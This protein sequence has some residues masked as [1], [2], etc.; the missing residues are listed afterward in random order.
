MKI[1]DLEIFLDL[2][3]TKSPTLTAQ[4]FKITQPNVSVLI[5]NIEKM[6]GI[7]LFERL[8]KRLVP[9]TRALYLGSL[10][11][12]VVQSYY[13][14]L[15][16]LGEEG[17]LIGEI[18]LV[19]THTI[20]EYFLPRILFDFAK[21]YPK[22]KV[23]LKIYNTQECLNLLKNGSVELALV[24][25][26]IGLEY[27]QSE[28][29]IREVLCE[30]RLIVASNDFILASKPRYIDE[31]LDKKWIF[32][33]YGSGLRDSFLNALGELKKE[34]PIFLELDRTTAI[35][36][37]VVNKGAIA[38]FSEVAIEQELKNGILF[39]IEIVNLNLERHFYSLKRKSHPI[40]TI[41]M[42]FEEFINESLQNKY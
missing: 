39:S 8:G 21:V 14:S 41:L 32:R 29:L 6:L 20:G 23:N 5:R 19:A 9:T 2:L 27:A 38:V 30:D 26:E 15:E 37:L 18:N 28:G 33:E 11:V 25:G 40:N 35:K 12:E 7:T 4:N 16:A 24:E 22:V 1:R 3:H 34:V 17:V 42:R 36:D 13:S 10:W 31:L